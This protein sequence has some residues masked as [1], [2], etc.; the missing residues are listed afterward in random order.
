MNT[1]IREFEM[2]THKATVT[3]NFIE[4][5]HQYDIMTVNKTY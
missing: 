4:S 5:L 2:I 3:N 1:A